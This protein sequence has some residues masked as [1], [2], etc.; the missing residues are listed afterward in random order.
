MFSSVQSCIY[1]RQD[2]VLMTGESDRCVGFSPAHAKI[3][4]V[5]KVWTLS[6]LVHV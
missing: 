2:L 1:L 4:T 3:I 6:W 5:V